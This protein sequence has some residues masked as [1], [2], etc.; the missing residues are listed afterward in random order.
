MKVNVN[1]FNKLQR[2]I[3][4]DTLLNNNNNVARSSVSFTLVVGQEHT[5]NN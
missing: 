5:T 3:K 1:G 2:L 4:T